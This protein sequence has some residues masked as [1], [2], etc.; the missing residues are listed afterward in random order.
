MRRKYMGDLTLTV[1]LV[2]MMVILYTLQSLLCKKY[3]DHYPGR[4]DMASPVFTIVSGFTVVIISLC[5]MGFRFEAQLATVLLGIL[6]SFVITGYNYFIVKTSQ[7]GPYSILMV[8]AVAGGIIIPTITDLIGF[9]VGVSIGK[10]IA[11]AVV[12]CAVYMMSYRGSGE[13]PWRRGFIPACFALGLTNG[14]Y[15]A[16]LNVQQNLTGE[17][18]K[19][20]LIAITYGLAAIMSLAMLLVKERGKL[21]AFRQSRLSLVF[22]ATCSIIVGLAINVLISIIPLMDASVLFTYDNAGTLLLSVVAS[23]I[24]FKE[25]LTRLNVIGCGVM[26][27]ALVMVTL[28]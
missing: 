11:I 12:F 17:S 7:T 13:A 10:A 14:V 15:S 9:G 8:F 16:I 5:F 22:L 19:E 28:L 18:E 20:E 21:S 24:F 26:C 25:K 3:T 6:N 4:E 27:V 2:V 23:C 1:V